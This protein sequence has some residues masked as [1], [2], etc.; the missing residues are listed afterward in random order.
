MKIGEKNDRKWVALIMI[1]GVVAIFAS[2]T[3]TNYN[4][5]Q[6]KIAEIQHN[7]S[8]DCNTDN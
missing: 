4:D 6:V 7:I 5:N 3:I 2:I 8:C 1:F